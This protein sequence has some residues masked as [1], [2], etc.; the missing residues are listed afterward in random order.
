[1][2]TLRL[3]LTRTRAPAASEL[4]FPHVC[5]LLVNIARTLYSDAPSLYEAV[6]SLLDEHFN[7]SGARCGSQL[8]PAALCKP[9]APAA[10]A[11]A[12]GAA[13]TTR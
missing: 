11:A 2:M 9:A 4:R 7:S 12:A 8:P 1:M 13:A 5:R 3:A 10:A 6:C